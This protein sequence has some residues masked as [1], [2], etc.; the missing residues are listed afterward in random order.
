M[1]TG[2][3]HAAEGLLGA[4]GPRMSRRIGDLARGI[5]D[6][7]FS[8]QESL[9]S[10]D[11]RCHTPC[12]DP[13]SGGGTVRS[14]PALRPSPL[15]DRPGQ[16]LVHP[17]S[18]PST[19]DMSSAETQAPPFP[20]GRILLVDDEHDFRTAVAELLEEKGYGVTACPSFR[21]ARIVVHS[22][23]F[24]LVMTE[25]NLP[26]GDGISLLWEARRRHLHARLFLHSSSKPLNLEFRTAHLGIEMFWIKFIHLTILLDR[27]SR[28]PK[29]GSFRGTGLEGVSVRLP[30]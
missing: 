7:V 25:F 11:F 17:G 18:A 23:D 26:E 20:R 6:G 3:T 16:A 15:D 24:D 22:G 9:S 2:A 12:P 1:K 21:E 27:M 29:E 5:Q 28:S 19:T 13:G 14:L 10:E 30:E 4:H 8:N